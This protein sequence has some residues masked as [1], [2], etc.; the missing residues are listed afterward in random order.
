MVWCGR[1]GSTVKFNVLDNYNV[2]E[3]H[4]EPTVELDVFDNHDLH[5]LRLIN[6]KS[7]ELDLKNIRE[8]SQEKNEFIIYN[9]LS[10]SILK[11]SLNMTEGKYSLE[12][13]I[14]T[15]LYIVNLAFHWEI[16]I[17]HNIFNMAEEEFSGPLSII[18]FVQ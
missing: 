18:K 3:I 16:I 1:G 8:K 6:T 4:S 10:D 17:P 9:V 5:V 13:Y 11:Q 2:H 14:L 15:L 7:G 12:S